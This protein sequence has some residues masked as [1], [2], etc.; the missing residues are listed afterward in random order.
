MRSIIRWPATSSTAPTETDPGTPPSIKIGTT[1]SGTP[2]Y[3]L[4]QPDAV[5]SFTA[6][7]AT[8]FVTANEGDQRVISGVDDVNDVNRLS[9][10]PNNLLTPELQ[11]LKSNPD[12]ARLNVVLRYGD[13]NND[14]VIDQLYTLG[15][16]GVSIFKQEADGSFTKV[17]ETGG[18]FEKFFAAIAA[19]ALQQRPGDRQYARRSLGQQ[20]PGA[21][22]HH[23][24]QVGGRTYAFIGLERQSGVMVYDVTDPA[25]ASFESYVPPLAGS[26]ADLGPE[27]LKFIAQRKIRPA[28]HCW[29]P[30]TRSRTAA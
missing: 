17:R 13:T 26:A 12:Y 29:R 20:G 4:L 6:N 11:A 15:G 25:N 19:D 8:Y 16:R 30:R 2:I 22:R 27:V 7:G 24:R 5:A 28:S 18:E 21:R 3:G 14:G 9:A 1:P 10:V 23:D